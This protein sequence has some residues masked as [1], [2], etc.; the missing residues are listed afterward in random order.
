MGLFSC[1]GNLINGIFKYILFI[2]NLIFVLAG[3]TILVLGILTEMSIFD[4]SQYLSLDI[5]TSAIVLMVG[6][7]TIVIVSFLGCCGA[8]SNSRCLLNLYAAFLLLALCVQVAG[9]VL[10]ISWNPNLS[11]DLEKEMITL[12]TDYPP[13]GLEGQTGEPAQVF[14]D[15]LQTQGECCGIRS[16]LDWASYNPELSRVPDS[17]L[18]DPSIGLCTAD[19]F[20]SR[21]CLQHLQETILNIQYIMAWTAIGVA[22]FEVVVGTLTLIFANSS[23][24]RK[25]RDQNQ[26]IFALPKDKISLSVQGITDNLIDKLR[27]HFINQSASDSN[28]NRSNM[29]CCLFDCIGGC[30]LTIFRWLIFILN[31]IFV[32][33][34]IAI[35]IFGSIVLAN[36]ETLDNFY[37]HK[38]GIGAIILVVSGGLV[39]IVS[40][41]GCCGTLNRS[42]RMLNTYAVF[43]L[44]I[45]ALQLSGSICSFA[46]KDYFTSKA[47]ANMEDLAKI[48]YVPG[49]GGDLQAKEAWDDMQSIYHCCGTQSFADWSRLRPELM[50]YPN[51]CNCQIFEKDCGM[52]GLYNEGCYNVLEPFLTAML[53]AAAVIGI[54]VAILQFIVANATPVTLGPVLLGSHPFSLWLWII[55]LTHQTLLA[56]SD[57]LLPGFH[58]TD[59]HDFHHLKFTQNYGSIGFLDRLLNTDDVFQKQKYQAKKMASK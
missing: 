59:F 34:G 5:H 2:F 50:G 19:G 13:A 1:I 15:T 22:A 25:D 27:L 36:L 4:I 10:V 40:F 6:G 7:G 30:V 3:I 26:R 45:F 54:I 11:V 8:I 43:L 24:N 17:C 38:T 42:H 12:M 47:L 52:N 56:H 9:F 35:I 39:V 55:Y 41:L 57:Y 18:C 33:A 44:V 49:F 48:Y 29:G 37:S 16:S 53:D 46:Y 31:L 32:I 28:T 21:G 20:Y 51:S 14:W 58:K 23:R